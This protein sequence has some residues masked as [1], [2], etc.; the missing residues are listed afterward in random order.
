MWWLILICKMSGFFW[1]QCRWSGRVKF[2]FVGAIQCVPREKC[3]LHFCADWFSLDTSL[4]CWWKYRC[5]YWG[6]GRGEGRSF[7][8]SYTVCPI[9]ECQFHNL[10]WFI[11]IGND[12]RTVDGIQVVGDWA[13]GSSC[14][15]GYTRIQQAFAVF[16]PLLTEPHFHKRDIWFLKLIL[17]L[18]I[19]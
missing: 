16:G 7:Y 9:K 17:Q 13:G 6:E 10:W 19:E 15:H 8:N 4:Y 14:Y 3:Q 12:V 11:L 18:Y 2:I 1:W 5:F